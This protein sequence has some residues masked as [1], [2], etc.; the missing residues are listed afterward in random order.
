MVLDQLVRGRRREKD[1]APGQKIA[2]L[3]TEKGLVV[4]IWSESLRKVETKVKDLWLSA[5][6]LVE[7]IKSVFQDPPSDL[8]AE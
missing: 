6:S 1:P 8:R 4:S 5:R 2:C 3:L 7:A